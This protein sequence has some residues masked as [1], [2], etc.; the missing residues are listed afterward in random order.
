MRG[1]NKKIA[2][3]LV[4]VFIGALLGGAIYAKEQQMA[5]GGWTE[6]DGCVYYIGES[7]R[8]LFGWQQIDGRQHYFNT[9]GALA[10]IQGVDVSEFQYGVD[11]RKVKEAGYEFAI[12]RLG[13]R[14]SRWEALEQDSYF[15]RNINEALDA[16]LSVGV[17]FYSQALDPAEAEEE[18]RYVLDSISPYEKVEY[19]I[20]FDIEETVVPGRVTA[21]EL[22]REEYTDV[23][24]AF[25]R[26]IQDAG[27]T[28]MIYSY[29]YILNERIDLEE[30]AEQGID[31]W[32]AYYGNPSRGFDGTF[33]IWQYTDTGNVPGIDGEADIDAAVVD[34]TG[35]NEDWECKGSLEPLPDENMELGAVRKVRA[36]SAGEESLRISWEKTANA[37]GYF[38]Y[39]RQNSGEYTRIAAVEETQFTDSQLIFGQ[40]YEYQVVA[41]QLTDQGYHVGEFPLTGTLP[42]APDVCVPEHMTAAGGKSGVR[43]DWSRACEADSY[44]VYKKEQSGEWQLACGNIKENFWLD[45]EVRQGQE[46]QYC[47]SAVRMTDDGQRH[48]SAPGG[49]RTVSLVMG[50]CGCIAGYPTLGPNMPEG[51]LTSY[52]L[53]LQEILGSLGYY[54]KVPDG[55]YGTQTMFG[56]Q[57]FQNDYNLPADRIVDGEVWRSLFKLRNGPVNPEPEAPENG[58]PREESSPESVHSQWKE[59]AYQIAEGDT[60]YGIICR[61]YGEFS[62]QLLEAF[63]R[64][65]GITPQTVLH[66]GDLVKIPDREAFH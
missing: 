66:G 24:L 60:Y 10:S 31:L 8:R 59:E 28:P 52:I 6:R 19:P 51:R 9:N 17:Y 33:A 42:A 27:Y 20:V 32:Y 46:Y 15:H 50:G 14:G 57:N 12:I 21:A 64:Y 29:Q 36:Q 2:F 53:E 49:V 63:C 61:F 65:N 11:W 22:T 34:Y 4:A 62:P 47:V 7:G 40:T 35:K 3:L 43:L 25:C 16:G 38:L 18:A 45:R 37:D 30:L 54:S 56:V 39:R 26:V 1:K 48:E 5:A 55:V 41:Y 23:A 44:C 13:Y 58:E